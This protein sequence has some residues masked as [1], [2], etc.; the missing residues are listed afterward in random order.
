MMH[1]EEL[2]QEVRS[3]VYDTAI[4]LA[5]EFKRASER[6]A[7]MIPLN[8]TKF[9]PPIL[10]PTTLHRESLIKQLSEIIT[11]RR[12]SAQESVARYKLLLL[13]TPVGYGKTTLLADFALS[14]QIPCCWYFLDQN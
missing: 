7:E 12:F 13:C 5:G 9:V 6:K 10:S 8:L 3:D 14:T 1:K 11:A 4:P 2:S